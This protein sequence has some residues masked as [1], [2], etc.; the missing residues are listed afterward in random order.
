LCFQ[1]Y[2]KTFDQ[3]DRYTRSVIYTKKKECI[4]F[5]KIMSGVS[6]SFNPQSSSINLYDPFNGDHVF[7]TKV[8]ADRVDLHVSDGSD[9]SLHLKGKQVNITNA[10]GQSITDVVQRILATKKSV[11]DETVARLSE[12]AIQR[13]ARKS[14]YTKTQNDIQAIS[15]DRITTIAD[16]KTHREGEEG[17]LTGLI[18]KETAERESAII[19]EKQNR[20][21][22]DTSLQNLLTDEINDRTT[23]QNALD[24]QIDT[25]IAT[26]TAQAGQRAQALTNTVASLEVKIATE[27][28]DTTKADTALQTMISDDRDAFQVLLSDQSTSRSDSDDNLRAIIDTKI[29]NLQSKITDERVRIT[30]LLEGS[31]IDLETFVQLVADYQS[32]DATL[33]TQIDTLDQNLSDAQSQFAENDDILQTLLIN[34]DPKITLVG[35]S[36]IDINVNSSYTELGATAFDYTGLNLT[37]DIVTSGVVDYTTIGAYNISYTVTDITLGRTV[38]VTRVVNVVS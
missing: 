4:F 9:L 23:K 8:S 17:I 33:L 22:D 29:A 27:E 6:S 19:L 2:V 21:V 28:S 18:N 14:I 11:A 31:S 1:N 32:E 7:Q 37:T 5:I 34:K 15:L 12:V 35:A 20:Q 26:V 16:H 10:T 3:R 38:S 25:E 30:A 36:T 13:N 24:A